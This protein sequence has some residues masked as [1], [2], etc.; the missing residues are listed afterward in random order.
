[1]VAGVGAQMKKPDMVTLTGKVID[2]TCSAKGKALMNS[3]GNALHE[4]H[5]TPDGKKANC[6]KMCLLGGQPAALFD[7]EGQSIEAVFACN[8]RA[9]LAEFATQDV[10]V[11]GFW[12][13]SKKDKGRSFF[14]QKI[15]KA[16][17]G[18]WKNVDCATMHG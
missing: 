14:P 12:A 5:M 6:A 15:R 11:M 3:W 13:G 1:M 8:P 9:T 17:S 18:T 16:G 2:L 4:D 10:E 7:T